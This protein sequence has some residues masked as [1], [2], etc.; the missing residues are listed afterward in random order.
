MISDFFASWQWHEAW[1]WL[2]IAVVLFSLEVIIPGFFFIWMALAATVVGLTLFLVP[3]TMPWQLLE[4]S[5]ASVI[6]VL[7]GKSIWGA[8]RNDMSDKPLLNLRGQQLIGQTFELAEEIKLGRGRVRVADG[9][10]NAR[11]S[12][13][14]A[15]AKVRVVGVEGTDLIVEAAGGA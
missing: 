12:D 9:L 10:W 15:G 4:F 5:V 1:N 3:L 13:M 14:P 8:Q 2:I 11:G 7:V 6:S